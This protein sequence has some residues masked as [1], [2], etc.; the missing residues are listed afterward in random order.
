MSSQ[1]D[2]RREVLFSPNIIQPLV[3]R[4]P[5]WVDH[6]NWEDGEDSDGHQSEVVVQ[7]EIGMRLKTLL[8]A[9]ELVRQNKMLVSDSDGK[10]IPDIIIDEIGGGCWAVIE[11][12]TLLEGDQLPAAEILEDL[13]KLCKYENSNPNALCMFMLVASENK[14]T[15][16][17]RQQNWETLPISINGDVFLSA[18]PRPQEIND[19]HVAIPWVMSSVAQAA[20]VYVWLIRHSTRIENPRVGSYRFNA[21][22]ERSLTYQPPIPTT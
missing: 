7:R 22:M 12:K 1:L 14:L 8:P 18:S 5:G 16:S 10:H 20:H 11:L 2:T 15:N 9:T 6:L 21:R 19:T 13:H 4:L 17:R 3:E